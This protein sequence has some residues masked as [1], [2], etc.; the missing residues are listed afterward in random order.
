MTV[1]N[2]ALNIISKKFIIRGNY[3]LNYKLSTIERNLFIVFI[4]SPYILILIM[5]IFFP[6][7]QTNLI[8]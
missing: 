7:S 6:D 5:S 2:K 1:Q 4:F 8:I 3:D